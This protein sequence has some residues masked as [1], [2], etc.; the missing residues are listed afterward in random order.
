MDLEVD[1]DEENFDSVRL[2]QGE[3]HLMPLRPL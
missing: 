1:G 3:H 2:Q